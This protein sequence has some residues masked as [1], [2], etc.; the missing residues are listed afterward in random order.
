MSQTIETILTVRRI[1]YII[2]LWL[3][4]GIIVLYISTPFVLMTHIH[5]GKNH[6]Y[7]FWKLVL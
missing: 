5:S 4:M 2:Y 6:K 3:E 1:L 7:K